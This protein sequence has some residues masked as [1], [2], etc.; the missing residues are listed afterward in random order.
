MFLTLF[1]PP[2]QALFALSFH[3]LFVCHETA[4]GHSSCHNGS[5][6]SVTSEAPAID[7]RITTNDSKV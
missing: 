4:D 7:V 6:S 1:G 2:L 3:K 5:A